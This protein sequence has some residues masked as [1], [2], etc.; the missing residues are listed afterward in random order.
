MAKKKR[1]RRAT[2]GAPT[3]PAPAAAPRDLEPA[4]P[5][6]AASVV[7]AEP[8][9]AT[10]G[11][12]PVLSAPAERSIVLGLLLLSAV[13]MVVA[14]TRNTAVCDELGA[15]IPAGYLYWMSGEYS[16]GV[17]NFPLGQLWI[18]LPVKLLGLDYELFTEQHLVLFRIPVM[19]LGLTLA[20]GVYRFTRRLFGQLAGLVALFVAV[21]SPNLLAHATLATLDLPTAFAVFFSVVTL[22]HYAHRP[23]AGRLA[24][25]AVVLAAALVVKIQT[26]LLVPIAGLALGLAAAR[27]P[28]GGT[29]SI[30]AMA[31][32]WVLLP[33]ALIAVVHLVYLELPS[34]ASW[35]LPQAYLEAFSA[36]LT[37]GSVGH[38]AYLFGAYSPTGWWYYFPVAILLKTPLPALLLVVLGLARRPRLDTVLFVLLPI[39]LF[40]GVGIAGQ[41]NIGLRHVLVI[42]PF[43]FVLAGAGASRLMAAGGWKRSA[44]GGLLVL[45]AAQA[46]WIQPH[47]LSY[48]NVLAG[49]SGNGYRFLLDSNYDWGQNDRYLERHVKETGLDYQID[50]DPFNPASGPI[51]VNANALY[52]LLN[53][54]PKAYGWLRDLQP[55]DRVAYTWFEYH[56]PESDSEPPTVVGDRLDRI[57]AHLEWIRRQD[58]AFASGELR[59]A[60]A[61]ALADVSLYDPAFELIRSIL[62]EQ[63]ANEDALRFGGSLIVRHKLGVLRYRGLEYLT[64]FRPPPAPAP[65]AP[66]QLIRDARDAGTGGVISATY[67]LLGFARF[68]RRDLDGAIEATRIAVALDGSNDVAAD[69]L[70]QMRE[71]KDRFSR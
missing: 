56:L 62:D 69:N 47:H 54:G 25:A 63:P 16:G 29:P 37:H 1:R 23:S 5:P 34:P 51:L 64:G 45:Y 27:R 21:L 50:P 60:T 19:A 31:A 18:A 32:S 33:A 11:L 26:V 12:K 2:K 66:E 48:F 28:R 57:G 46:A 30:A 61:Q 7:K 13:I 52:G 68:N 70:R 55:D 22:Y 4:V 40:L 38:F 20:L 67:T 53:G 41:V 36:K 35:L 6:G 9:G 24:V 65:L 44:L 15:H 59:L 14:A 58:P 49:G 8:G 39:V 3:T 10:V 71:I 42:Y 17:D 43:F